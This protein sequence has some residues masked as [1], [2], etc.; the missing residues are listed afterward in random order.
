[1]EAS[2]G[3]LVLTKGTRHLIKHLQKE[4]KGNRLDDLR[5]DPIDGTTTLIK[6]VFANGAVDLLWLTN[7]VKHRHSQRQNPAD[8][9]CLLP[10][11][12]SAGQAHLEA[13]WI[14]FLTASN[15]NVLTPTNHQKIPDCISTVLNDNSYGSIDLRVWKEQPQ[16]RLLCD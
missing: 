16:P 5:N 1:M 12:N 15:N 2:M 10:D 4:F 8:M 13:R 3:G 7:N 6:D 9:K 11:D 14:Y